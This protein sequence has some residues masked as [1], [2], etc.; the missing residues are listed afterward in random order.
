MSDSKDEIMEA[1]YKALC[2]HGYADLSIQNIADESEK[3]KSLIYYH[4]DNKQ[5]LM[6]AFMDH[7][8]EEIKSRQQKVKGEE[9]LDKLDYM[10][11]MYLGIESDKMW[12]FQKAFQEFRAQA[13]HNP[14]FRKKFQEIDEIVKKDTVEIMRQAQACKPEIA[15]EMFL[16]LIEG[17]IT[18]KVSTE[19]RKGL[20]DLKE[21]IKNVTR[22][23][24]KE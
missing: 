3:G 20:E 9:P 12:E 19:D 13:Q 22:S 1:T 17:S 10:L 18:R 2:K 21:E 16:S 24:L 23:F 5:E 8:K 11:D 6:K 7:M 4:Y 14:E 15:T